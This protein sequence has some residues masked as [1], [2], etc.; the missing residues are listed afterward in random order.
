MGL[1]VNELELISRPV[2][3]GEQMWLDET[4]ETLVAEGDPRAAFLFATEGQEISRADA[5]RYGLVKPSKEEKAAEKVATTTAGGTVKDVLAEVGDD[6]EKATAALEAEQAS[7]KP[8]KSLV[9]KLEA[10]VAAADD[11]SGGA[12]E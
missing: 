9:E 11:D 12:G 6:A 1:K 3:A 8:R 4:R 2:V 5:V 10:I 7:E